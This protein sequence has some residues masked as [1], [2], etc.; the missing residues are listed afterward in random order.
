MKAPYGWGWS[1]TQR[2]EEQKIKGVVENKPLHV[3]SNDTKVVDC[4][5]K[6]VKTTFILKTTKHITLFWD[7]KFI[8]KEGSEMRFRIMISLQSSDLTFI[9]T[10]LRIT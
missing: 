1:V 8:I 10:T 3:K 9:V 7:Q 4:C 6:N 5:P 2:H